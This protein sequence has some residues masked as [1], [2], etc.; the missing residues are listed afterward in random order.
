MTRSAVIVALTLIAMAV[1]MPFALSI[2]AAN[3][4]TTGYT[5]QRVEHNVQV[6]YSGQV[7]INETI[8]LSGQMPSSFTLGL[9][10]RYGS[11]LLKGTAVDSNNK[12]LPVT[13]G[14]QLQDKVGFYGASISLPAGTSNIFTVI[15]I[16]SNGINLDGDGVQPGFSSLSQLPPNSK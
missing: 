10:Y 12:V 11:Y 7:V 16:L 3:A 2:Q 15:L 8:Q 13:L 9:P 14:V 1:F 5:I 6:L 4:Q